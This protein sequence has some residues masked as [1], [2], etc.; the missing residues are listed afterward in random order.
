[1][2]RSTH[3]L[4]HTQLTHYHPRVGVCLQIVVCPVQSRASDQRC[5]QVSHELRRCVSRYPMRRCQAVDASG[6]CIH[7]MR[8]ARWASFNWRRENLDFATFCMLARKAL[9]TP[10][11]LLSLNMALDSRSSR[12]VKVTG[13][14]DHVCLCVENRIFRVSVDPIVSKIKIRKCEKKVGRCF[15]CVFMHT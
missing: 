15:G 6:Q 13:R 1:M 14:G 11:L 8:G 3:I 2:K 12:S 4:L 10:D 5:T 9:A 7:A